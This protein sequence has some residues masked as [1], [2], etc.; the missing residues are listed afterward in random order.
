MNGRELKKLERQIDYLAYFGK[1]TPDP[2]ASE[3]YFQELNECQY[4][5]RRLSGKF[6]HQ[7][8]KLRKESQW[9]TFLESLVI[10]LKKWEIIS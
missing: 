5:H 7:G 4:R 1:F 3:V 6:Y 8:N 10:Y 2:I 9:E